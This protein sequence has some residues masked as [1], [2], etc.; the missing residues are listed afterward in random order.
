MVSAHKSRSF[1]SNAREFFWPRMGWSRAFRYFWLR[2]NRL[3]ATPHSISLGFAFGA[4]S[5]FTPFMGLHI[6]LAWLLAH[7]FRG[8]MIAAIV[9]T[10]V[11][12]PFTFPLIWLSTYQIGAR[13]LGDASE[14]TVVQG[15]SFLDLL[16]GPLDQAL[17]IVTKMVVG[18]VP[19]G[20]LV[21]IL[22]YVVVRTAIVGFQR[23]RRLRLKQ[24]SRRRL[25][26]AR[27]VTS[28]TN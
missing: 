24:A 5:S 12:N 28:T 16:G 11:G 18:A 20:I 9:G 17:P 8:N 3:R 2:L 22:C 13:F 4:F 1:L 15:S 14:E 10:V 7:I 23:N 21:S 6:A 26:I 27:M 19:L 25:R